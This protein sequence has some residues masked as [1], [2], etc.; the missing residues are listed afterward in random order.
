MGLE[1]GRAAI[2]CQN[3]VEMVMTYGKGR[4]R[5]K[6]KDENLRPQ[7]GKR[8]ENGGKEAEIRIKREGDRERRMVATTLVPGEGERNR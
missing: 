2:G 4:E 6:K 1:R 7:R 3:R 5:D 8:L